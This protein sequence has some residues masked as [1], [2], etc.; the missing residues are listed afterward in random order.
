MR[1]ST[2]ILNS[3]LLATG[4]AAP[5]IVKRDLA[6]I[7]GALKTVETGLGK[8]TTAVKSI[9]TDPQSGPPVL[10]ASDDLAKIIKQATTDINASQELSLQDALTLQQSSSGLTTAVKDTMDALKGKKDTLDQLGFTKIAIQT[11]Q[12]QKTDSTALGKAIVSKIPAIGQSI[13]Q[14]A[15]DGVTNQIDDG[16]KALQ[17]PP[18]AG[19]APPAAGASPSPAAPAAPKQSGAPKATPA[20]AAPAAPAPAPAAGNANAADPLAGVLGLITGTG[21]QPAVQNKAATNPVTSA[22]GALLGTSGAQP[23]AA[24]PAAGGAPNVNGALAQVGAIAGLNNGKGQPNTANP[25]SQ[26]AGQL[27]NPKPAAAARK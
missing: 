24:A 6:S 9:T 22:T 18:A 25:I 17:A 21:A 20:P 26:A 23:A 3:L 13:A 14:Q 15:V 1:A 2:V 4:L 7:Q 11:L 12:T 27:L 8:L 19:A 5:A 16:I 10:S